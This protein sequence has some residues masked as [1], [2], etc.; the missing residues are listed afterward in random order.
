MALT[1]QYNFDDLVNEAERFV[2]AELEDQLAGRDQQVDEDAILD[3]AAFALNKVSPRYRVNLLGRL[4]AQSAD[5]A[6][7]VEV[8]NAVASALDK[9]LGA[10]SDT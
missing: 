7:V 1:D 8:R 2:L 3:M 6:Y 4:Y 9:I 10:A 5:E